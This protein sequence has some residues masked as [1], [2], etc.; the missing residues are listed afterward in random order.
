M[1]M[2]DQMSSM[3]QVE[4]KFPSPRTS[5]SFSFGPIEMLPKLHRVVHMYHRPIDNHLV[6]SFFQPT[7]IAFFASHTRTPIDAKEKP[8]MGPRTIAISTGHKTF[9]ISPHL[10]TRRDERMISSSDGYI[11][12][13]LIGCEEISNALKTSHIIMQL[14]PSWSPEIWM[15]PK[16]PPTKRR[17]PPSLHVFN[18]CLVLHTLSFKCSSSHPLKLEREFIRLSVVT[19]LPLKEPM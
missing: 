17:V 11:E 13:D 12:I 5:H 8:S 15:K 16:E 19:T 4:L 1:W 18:A 3:V 14:P 10:S 2:V 6:S 7:I 9:L